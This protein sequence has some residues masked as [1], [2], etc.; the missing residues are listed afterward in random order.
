MDWTW[1]IVCISLIGTILNIK[2]NK[3]GFAF[4]IVSNSLWAAYDFYT[5]L[6]SQAFLFLVYDGLAIW[7]ILEW[8][9]RQIAAND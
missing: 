2:Q 7:G 8:R 6:Y 3:W 5:G 9:R 1:F 4:W